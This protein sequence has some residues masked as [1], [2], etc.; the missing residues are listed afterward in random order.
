MVVRIADVTESDIADVSI[1][2][3]TATAINAAPPDEAPQAPVLV[4]M[5][6]YQS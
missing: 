6:P 4:K 3:P 1:E 5:L 2:V